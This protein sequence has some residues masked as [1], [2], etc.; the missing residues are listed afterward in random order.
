MFQTFS[1]VG[2]LCFDFTFKINIHKQDTA[3]ERWNCKKN[4]G[5]Q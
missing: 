4:M 1:T 3:S 5:A 2:I